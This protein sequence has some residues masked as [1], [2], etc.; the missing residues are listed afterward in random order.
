M[1]RLLVIVIAA[2][3]LLTTGFFA[4]RYFFPDD[5]TRIIRTLES[6]ADAVGCSPGES[7]P[8]ASGKIRRIESL[9]G[10]SID[11]DLRVER[12]TRGRTFSRGEIVAV[13][14]NER[15]SGAR[16]KVELADFTVAV[17]G[18]SADAEA[19]A[20]IYYRNGEREFS[21]QDELKI[22]LV[23]RDGKWLITRLHIRN[24]MEK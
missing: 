12:E 3:A 8:A 20:T 19:A 7:A 21:Q 5:E 17:A 4:W 18:D 11:I 2:A 13:L 16:V 24:F 9:I 10:D 23:R 6:A 1:T 22:G 15:R 14:A